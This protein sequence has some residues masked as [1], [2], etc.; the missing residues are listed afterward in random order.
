M[1]E[2]NSLTYGAI[3]F[4]LV[5][6]AVIFI[7]RLN[8]RPLV[9]MT[10]SEKEIFEK[11]LSSSSKTQARRRRK[12]RKKKSGKISK[13]CALLML[14]LTVCVSIVAVWQQSSLTWYIAS[15][16][17]IFAFVFRFYGTKLWRDWPVA[18]PI[19]VYVI[20]WFIYF[21]NFL[22]GWR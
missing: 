8:R 5:V 22:K 9:I 12:P 3:F 11:K 7:I 19:G 18:W 16:A 10:D 17:P 2:I 14:L 21:I 4:A 13:L 15:I 6:L 20:F 1:L